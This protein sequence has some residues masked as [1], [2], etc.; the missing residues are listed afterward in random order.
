MQILDPR[1]YSRD[2]SRKIKS[3]RYAHI[4][5][6][7]YFCS[8]ALYK[9]EKNSEDKH[10]LVLDPPAAAM[11]RRIFDMTL[12]DMGTREIACTL[13]DEDV[14]TPLVYMRLKYPK[15]RI[16]AAPDNL[17][18]N[19]TVPDILNDERYTG[20]AISGERTVAR[21]DGKKRHR[22]SREESYIVPDSFEAIVSEADFQAAQAC[23]NHLVKQSGAP[24]RPSLLQAGALRG[25]WPYHHAPQQHQRKVILL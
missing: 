23:I 20:K 15:K 24:L 8:F 12:A 9:Y 25:L 6:G 10:K 3:S 4:K 5:R 2:I 21:V 22:T 13:N 19:H 17:G 16:N 7:D 14:P 1:L 11:A 18:N